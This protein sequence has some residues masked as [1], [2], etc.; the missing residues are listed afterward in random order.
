MTT[1]KRAAARPRN[2][3]SGEDLTLGARIERLATTPQAEVRTLSAELTPMTRSGPSFHEVLRLTT[4]PDSIQPF[5][6]HIVGLE[7]HS[8]SQYGRE[9]PNWR[10]P[11]SWRL[12]P[13]IIRWTWGS[14]AIV[15]GTTV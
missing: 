11:T 9:Q 1:T 4:D 10:D 14:F 15:S 12:V 2:R 13:Y 3:A 5:E 8:S 6:L 7:G